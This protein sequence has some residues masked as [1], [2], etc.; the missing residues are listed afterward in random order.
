MAPMPDSPNHPEA[1]AVDL[2]WHPTDHWNGTIRDGDKPLAYV[3]VV[4]SQFDMAALLASVRE[5][6]ELREAL[7]QLRGAWNAHMA[8]CQLPAVPGMTNEE[9]FA[10]VEEWKNAP[11][12]TARAF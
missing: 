6:R 8:R 10:K 9:F 11:S 2:N 3:Q 12:G 1:V 5:A 4:D 7:E